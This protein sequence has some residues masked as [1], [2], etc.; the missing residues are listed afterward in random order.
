MPSIKP[1]WLGLCAAILIGGCSSLPSP[2][3]K[4]G[5]DSPEQKPV[6]S[7]LQRRYEEALQTLREGDL[8]RAKARFGQLAE[9][10]PKLSGPLI[11]LG[12]IHLKQ[13]DPEAA[14]QALREALSR[15]PGSAPA[16]NQLGVTLRMLG[17]FKEAEQAYRTA[18][19]LDPVYPLAHRNLGILYDLYLAEPGKALEQYRICQQMAEAPDKEIKGWI[20]DLERRTGE[21]R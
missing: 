11:N 20:L 4:S 21:E 16:H 13:N 7:A 5:A 15:N 10:H 3:A 12:I 2:S 6:D 17:R 8:D 19:E 9:E 14:E 1:L 18:L